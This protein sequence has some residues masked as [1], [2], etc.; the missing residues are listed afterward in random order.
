MKIIVHTILLIFSTWGLSAQ[1]QKIYYI[2]HSLINLNIP[3]MVQQLANAANKPTNYRHHINIG[4]P[5]KLNWSEPW[6][7]NGD[8]HWVASQNREVEHGTDFL[9]ELS[10]TGYTALVI[11]EA[12]GFSSNFQWNNSILHGQKF[13]SVARRANPL[14]KTYCYETWNEVDSNNFTKW[15]QNINKDSALWRQMAKGIRTDGLIVP[16]GQ[17]MAALYD[18]LQQGAV[19]RLTNINQVFTDNIHLTN[20]GNYYMA[21][22]MYAT[23]FRTSPEGLPAIGAGPFIQNTLVETDATTRTALQR[24]AWQTVRNYPLSGALVSVNDAIRNKVVV[25]PNPVQNQ[26]FL[27]NTEGV[28][29]IDLYD[30]QGR[31][32][33]SFPNQ[34]VLDINNL[35][36]GMYVL[37]VKTKFN[38]H[39]LK[40]TKM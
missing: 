25:Y 20:T 29:S 5:L 33:K 37:L 9:I 36:S 10:N 30:L 18:A 4:A 21:L 15:R 40:I 11:T 3:F 32:R 28:H 24:L 19:G 2:G 6:K 22:V 39:S 27:A 12:Q 16:G 34:Q 1:Q 35:P 26:I 31:L 23:L 14:I 17:A 7:F 13:D 8:L 38:T